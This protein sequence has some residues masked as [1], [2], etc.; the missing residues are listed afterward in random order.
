MALS[1]GKPVIFYCDED[2][3]TGFY[4]DV[5]PL[6]RLINFETGVA[7]GVMVAATPA[8]VAELLDRIF[9]NKMQYEVIQPHQAYLQLRERL[10]GSIVRLQ[11]NDQLLGEAFWNYYKSHPS[12]KI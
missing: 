2:K 12:A 5:H 8:D 3:R 9:E 4:R 10:T 7:V 11:T 6:S 1:L